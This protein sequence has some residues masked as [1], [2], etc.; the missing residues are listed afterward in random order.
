MDR[1]E[2]RARAE[3]AR[4]AAA[5]AADDGAATDRPGKAYRWPARDRDAAP[6]RR[7][8]HGRAVVEGRRERHSVAG[9]RRADVRGERV[10][11]PQGGGPSSI[12]VQ[13]DGI[14]SSHPA[15]ERLRYGR[16]LAWS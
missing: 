4:A 2:G 5:P 7:S 13:R 14:R 3:C 15:V 11:R 10:A 16:A 6:D 9:R 8:R 12:G 1:G